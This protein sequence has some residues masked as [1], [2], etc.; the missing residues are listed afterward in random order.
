MALPSS[1]AISF[2]D[3]NTEIGRSS[4][5][6]TSLNDTLVRT[7]FGQAS[8]AVDM[9]TGHAKAYQFLFTINLFVLVFFK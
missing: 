2:S 4:T 6:Q 1:G 8:G 3:I 5:A 7:V 9:N